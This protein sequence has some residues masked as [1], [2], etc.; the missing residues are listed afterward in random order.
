MRQLIRSKFSHKKAY[1]ITNRLVRRLLVEIF[2]TCQ[3]ILKT[4]KAGDMELISS[5]IL[6]TELCSLGITMSCK[7]TG[8]KNLEV[9]SSDFEKFF[10][11]NTGYDCITKLEKQVGGR[12]DGGRGYNPLRNILPAL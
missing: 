12:T 8:F 2:A 3:A 7:S 9:V 4:F 5:A 1:H 6:W 10:L 11:V